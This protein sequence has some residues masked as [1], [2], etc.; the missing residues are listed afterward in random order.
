[1]R[2]F[3]L[4][5]ATPALPA[6]FTMAVL[7]GGT[8]ACGAPATAAGSGGGSTGGGGAPAGTGGATTQ[9]PTDSSQAAIEAFLA[10]GAY[11]SW[12][13]DPAPRDSP[14]GLAGMHPEQVR[15]FFN[16]A[17]VESVTRNANVSSPTQ[18]EGMVIVKEIYSA[19]GAQ[20]A[21][22]LRYQA[23]PGSRDIAWY[24]SGE[25]AACATTSG[26]P[27]YGSPGGGLNVCSTCHG[28]VVFA[29]LPQ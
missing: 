5:L 25:Q 9:A 15:V 29:P 8:T 7:L 21:T 22:A 16:D 26:T 6:V 12:K 28:S 17:A 14:T 10:T 19:Q 13:S 1:M 24:C 18:T 20:V 23:G 2:P 3:Q 11:Q 4:P 27:F